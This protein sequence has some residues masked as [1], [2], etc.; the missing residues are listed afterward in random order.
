MNGFER[1]S[2]AL[3][4]RP[5]DKTP[6]ML[7]NFMMAAYEGGFTMEQFRNDPKVIAGAFIKSIEKYCYDGIIVDV[8]TVTLAG[9]TGVPIDFPVSDSHILSKL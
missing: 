1:I 4:G 8:D 5:A 3:D 7:H 2:A 6:I 9:S